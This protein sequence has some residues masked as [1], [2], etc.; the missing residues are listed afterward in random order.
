[1]ACSS[2]LQH[3]LQIESSAA[4]KR[5]S[6]QEPQVMNRQQ[7]KAHVSRKSSSL[8]VLEGPYLQSEL[9]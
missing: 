9:E 1:M 7:T 3:F 6:S 2:E 5:G 8:E 4:G